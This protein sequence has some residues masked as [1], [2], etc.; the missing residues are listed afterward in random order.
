MVS[1]KCAMFD[2][3]PGASS[4]MDK[5]NPMRI[6]DRAGIA[7]AVHDY[8]DAGALPAAEVAERLG[9]EPARVFKTLVTKSKGD[10]CYVFVV[11]ATGELDLKKA[12]VA[13]GEKSVSMMPSK[14]LLTVTG[15]VHGGC[16]PL[17]MRRQFRTVVDATAAEQGRFYMS[18]GRVGLQIEMSFADLSKVLDYGLADILRRSL[19]V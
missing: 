13:V 1:A 11:P 9:E 3:P 2:I 12:A 15:Y 7:Y 10:R 8:S 16:S 19:A 6:L 4:F 5:T 18:A 14:D 17:G